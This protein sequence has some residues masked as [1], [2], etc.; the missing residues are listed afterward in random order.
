MNGL[1]DPDDE[2]Y[3]DP[4]WVPP[5]EAPRAHGLPPLASPGFRFLARL[6]D[7]V[8]LYVVLFALAV[9]I[10]LAYAVA[11]GTPPGPDEIDDDALNV[12]S[13]VVGACGLFMYEW[14]F[15]ALWS[16]TPGKLILRMRVRRAVDDA[17]LPPGQ[18]AA[19]PETD[20]FRGVELP[21]GVSPW[22]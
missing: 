2:P 21:R 16:A 19:P 11:S 14:F 4:Y 7:Q 1:A 10:Y 3:D 6:I 5:E 9:V 13:V 20:R 22:A 17:P 15:L 8:I 18:A 12:A